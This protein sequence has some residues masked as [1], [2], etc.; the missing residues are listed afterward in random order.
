MGM[1]GVG[2]IKYFWKQF[3]FQQERF[4]STPP[5]FKRFP[6]SFK[7]ATFPLFL[8]YFFFFF[9][10]SKISLQTEKFPRNVVLSSLFSKHRKQL[11]MIAYNLLKL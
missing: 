8:T 3:Y 7:V 2:N 1:T 6:S 4:P 10:I 9:E 5:G 11:A